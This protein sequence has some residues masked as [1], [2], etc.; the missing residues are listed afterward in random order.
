MTPPHRT[1]ALVACTLLGVARAE[2]QRAPAEA[3]EPPIERAPDEVIVIEDERP[4]GRLA[5][6]P[7]ATEQIDREALRA[8]G[9]TTATAAL[10]GRPG[11][12]IDRGRGGAAPSLQGLGPEYVVILIDGRRQVG[13]VDGAIDLDRFATSELDAI[14][15]VRGPGAVTYGADAIAG[16]INLRTR[17]VDA[18]RVT[19]AAR[20]DHRGGSEARGAIA[21]GTAAVAGSLAVRWA[22]AP[23]IDRGVADPATTI[24]AFDDAQV[25]GRARVGL[26]ADWRLELDAGYQYRDLRSVEAAAGGAVLDR[27]NRVEVAGGQLTAARAGLGTRVAAT[28]AVSTYR[29]QFAHDQR[30]GASLDQ[31]QDTREHL[32]DGMV[33]LERRIAARHLVSGGAA[34]ARE[35]LTTE[36]LTGAGRNHRA[37]LW[38]Q[39]EWRLGDVGA[40]LLAPAARVDVD[41]QFGWHATPRLAARWDVTPAMIARGSVGLGYRAPSFKEQL[42]RFENPGAGYVV[43]GN[44][45][46]RPELARSLQVALE[47]R[48]G[49]WAAMASGYATALTD[50]ITARA[51]P[52]MPG[53]ATEFRYANVG[54]AYTAGGE[55]A[56]GWGRGRFGLE[57]GYAHGWSRDPETGA[58]LEGQPRHRGQL[59]ARWHDPADGL[60]AAI[61]AVATGSRRYGV[62]A[63]APVAAARVELRAR[64]ARRFAAGFELAVGGDNL[65]GAGDADLDRLAPAT[66]YLALEVER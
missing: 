22:Q 60:S 26:A 47:W 10:A 41:Q 4:A 2:G 15:V 48:T 30:G 35:G 42:L 53:A 56:V 45:G 59:A 28:L 13:R 6:G 50:L 32:I 1:A 39:D 44:P 38:L 27:H 5:P 62:D 65:L 58:A 63:A 51:E 19:L 36:R 43:L 37:A 9:A 25:D 52:A 31:Y 14:E 61:E 23:A 46:L 40:V 24:A 3:P 18:E 34:L 29:D 12:W 16:V 7:V 20:A 8:T 66:Y 49:A 54:R 57:V 21:G 33:Q 64:V 11:V 17:A 55:L